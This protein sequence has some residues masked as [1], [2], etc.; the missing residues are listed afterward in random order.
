MPIATAK[1]RVQRR[2]NSRRSFKRYPGLDINDYTF[3]FDMLEICPLIIQR[4]LSILYA[5]P[6][7]SSTRNCKYSPPLT[8]F[9]FKLTPCKTEN[10]LIYKFN[11][12]RGFRN[13][14]KTKSG[15]TL[16]RTSKNTQFDDYC[17]W[18]DLPMSESTCFRLTREEL[19]YRQV[20][21]RSAEAILLF[22]LMIIA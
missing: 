11:E 20:N 2:N 16:G 19:F 22:L 9:I 6:Y 13:N 15:I 7:S 4:Q 18:F 1:K 3:A 8:L 5:Y 21:K 12:H 17:S 10:K 14:C